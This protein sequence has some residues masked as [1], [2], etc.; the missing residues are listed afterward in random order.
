MLARTKPGAPTCPAVAASAR[1]VCFVL[2]DTSS[3]HEAL[4]L[5]KAA[6]V[7]CP[8]TSRAGAHR[9]ASIRTPLITSLPWSKEA[10]QGPLTV[11]RPHSA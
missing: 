8:E 3:V 5:P 9:E 10:L 4:I 7:G 1:S 6:K 2:L 11:S